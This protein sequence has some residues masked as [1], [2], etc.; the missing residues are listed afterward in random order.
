M[1]MK[2]EQIATKPSF[3][4]GAITA[5]GT[6]FGVGSG[7]ALGVIAIPASMIM[8][9]LNISSKGGAQQPT[10]KEAAF[11]IAFCSLLGGVATGTFSVAADYTYFKV[12]NSSVPGAVSAG[13]YS[14]YSKFR[15]TFFPDLAPI[16]SPEKEF[17][18]ASSNNKN[19]L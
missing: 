6:S 11:I 19:S 3:R 13:V 7:L 4:P 16:P 8:S 14:S 17:P 1:Q 15:D 12:K 9:G 5:V 10:F 2:Y 18:Q